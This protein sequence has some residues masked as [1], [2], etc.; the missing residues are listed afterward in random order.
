MRRGN[1]HVNPHP[2]PWYAG[3]RAYALFSSS[4][5]LVFFFPINGTACPRVRCLPGT[6]AS[7]ADDWLQTRVGGHHH[8]DGQLAG[9]R[10]CPATD[11]TDSAA[12]ED[13]LLGGTQSLGLG[14]PL[15]DGPGKYSHAPRDPGGCEPERARR[16]R[17]A[18][19]C[20]CAA[21]RPD[22]PG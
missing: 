4:I 11:G 18:A 15:P 13:T 20:G 22:H 5:N 12:I 6:S 8:R 19:T 17:D 10:V 9:S 16:R 14:E 7:D 21:A 2:R 1:R 3:K